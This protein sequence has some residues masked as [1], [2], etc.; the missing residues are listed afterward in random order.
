MFSKLPLKYVKL[1]LEN[2]V[3]NARISFAFLREVISKDNFH[4]VFD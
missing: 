1:S 3:L 2:T 4:P